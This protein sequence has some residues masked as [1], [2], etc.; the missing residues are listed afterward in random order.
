L[1]SIFTGLTLWALSVLS[2]DITTVESDVA[3]IHEKSQESMTRR[4]TS[5]PGQVA[6]SMKKTTTNGA[7]KRGAVREQDNEIVQELEPESDRDQSRA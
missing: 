1:S 6:R 5:H 4:K 7:K 3:Y 2:S